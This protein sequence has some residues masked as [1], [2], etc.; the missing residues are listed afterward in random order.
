[1]TEHMSPF[2]SVIEGMLPHVLSALEAECLSSLY[3]D[4]FLNKLTATGN[5]NVARAA[6]AKA[7]AH[8][9][10]ENLELARKCLT[11]AFTQLVRSSVNDL[12]VFLCIVQSILLVQDVDQAAKV[13]ICVPLFNDLLNRHLT[14]S[15]LSFN[16]VA[17]AFI[18]TALKCPPLANVIKDKASSFAYISDWLSD[19]NYP[20]P[21]KASCLR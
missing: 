13:Q 14:L 15:Y 2:S 1:M 6:I 4:S 21:G 8:V 16:Y 12:P 17:D 10:F 18:T 7:L 9:S 11:Y 5:T 19:N 20:S 3:D